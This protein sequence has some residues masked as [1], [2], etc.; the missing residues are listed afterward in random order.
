MGYPGD[1]QEIADK[2]TKKERQRCLSW[3]EWFGY[4]NETDMRS[5]RN[6]IKGGEW[7]TLD[8]REPNA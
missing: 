2:A 3:V 1:E 7:P 4:N 6:V 8:G 5:V